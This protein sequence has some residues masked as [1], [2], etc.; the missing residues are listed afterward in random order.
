MIKLLVTGCAGFI[1]Y[2]LCENLL[3]GELEVIGI[4]N[5]NAYR[6]DAVEHK[7]R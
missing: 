7:M 6:T 1:D 2:H 4:G 3:A 5:L